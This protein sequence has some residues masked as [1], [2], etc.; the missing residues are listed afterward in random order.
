[1][2]NPGCGRLSAVLNPGLTSNT[3]LWCVSRPPVSSFG[4]DMIH[5]S[6]ASAWGCIQLRPLRGFDRLVAC[7]AVYQDAEFL[8]NLL[9]KDVGDGCG[10]EGSG[11]VADEGLAGLEGEFEGGGAAVSYAGACI[12]ADAVGVGGHVLAAVGIVVVEA[13]RC[14]VESRQGVE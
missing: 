8:P 7:P 4:H 2:V 12:E 3:T 5:I 1:M 13:P 10:H 14:I 6:R 11:V 9:L